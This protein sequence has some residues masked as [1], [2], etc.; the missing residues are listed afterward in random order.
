VASA[1]AFVASLLALTKNHSPVAHAASASAS[2]SSTRPPTNRARTRVALAVPPLST[3]VVVV[4]V[5]V[6]AMP[7]W[8]PFVPP[9]PRGMIGRLGPGPA[10]SKGGCRGK[11]IHRWPRAASE[12]SA[13]VAVWRSELGSQISDG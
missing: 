9:W 11:G 2:E 7:I 4:V 12:Y 13:P 3:A 6:T 10:S 1:S 8:L 5:S